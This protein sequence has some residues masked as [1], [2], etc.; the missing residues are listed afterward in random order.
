MQVLRVASTLMTVQESKNEKNKH[1]VRFFKRE[2]FSKSVVDQSWDR[3]KIICSQ[4]FNKSSQY[5]LSFIKIHSK[6][7]NDVKGNENSALGKFA[8]KKDKKDDDVPSALGKFALKKDE[9][10]DDVPSIGS[11]FAR[12]N[13]APEPNKISGEKKNTDAQAPTLTF[14]DM[15]KFDRPNKKKVI[16]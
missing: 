4:P 13:D 9:K 8:L 11:F 1:A 14:L 5:G 16:F 15:A 10:D 12:R 7:S 3:I 2:E 6:S